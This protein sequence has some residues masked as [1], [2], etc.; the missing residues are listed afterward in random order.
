MTWECA[1]MTLEGVGMTWEGV[2]AIRADR[3]YG[4]THARRRFRAQYHRSSRPSWEA[5]CA[6][7]V[8]FTF[9][10][11][12]CPVRSRLDSPSF[13]RRRESSV[14]RD[15]T[16]R[17]ESCRPQPSCPESKRNRGGY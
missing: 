11:W 4:R 15:W 17:L 6:A 14:L 9:A 7:G 10:A 1:G 5:P 8:P 2:G 12:M 3:L 13:P 16:H